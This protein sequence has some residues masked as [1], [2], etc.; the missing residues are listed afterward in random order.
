MSPRLSR[1]FSIARGSMLLAGRYPIGRC[2]LALR[3]WPERGRSE[4]LLLQRQP[5]LHE[6]KRRPRVL[7][8]RPGDKRPMP[9]GRPPGAQLPARIDRSP[10]LRRRLCVDG[11]FLLPRRPIDLDRRLLSERSITGRP[12]Q[13]PVS[14]ADPCS[15]RATMLRQRPRPRRDRRLLRGGQ[16][17]DHRHVL[18]GARRSQGSHALPGA[19]P[20]HYRV[21]TRLHQNAGWFLLQRSLPRPRRKVLSP[22]LAAAAIASAG[23]A[24]TGLLRART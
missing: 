7:P 22:C 4:P 8:F 18:L 9:A 15:G 1:A 20:E 17:D 12:Q 24:A 13:Q 6:R 5:H 23:A 16:S 10:M 21:R 19:N 2:V 3:T 14:A 11:R